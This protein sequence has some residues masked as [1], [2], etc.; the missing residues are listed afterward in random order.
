MSI[1]GRNT[2]TPADPS[3][4]ICR[5]CGLYSLGASQPAQLAALSEGNEIRRLQGKIDRLTDHLEQMLRVYGE[6]GFVAQRAREE[7]SRSEP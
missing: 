5:A 3:R 7:L 6:R 4:G 1:E 2:I